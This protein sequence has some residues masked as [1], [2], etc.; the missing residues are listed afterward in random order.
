MDI[1]LLRQFVVSGEYELEPAWHVGGL[2]AVRE[3]GGICSGTRYHQF[4]K[5]PHVYEHEK[6]EWFLLYR[7]GV[8]VGGGIR[9]GVGRSSTEGTGH[10]DCQHHR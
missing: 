2:V 7:A 1:E 10:D 5:I 8:F 4:E 6:Q 9:I 3:V